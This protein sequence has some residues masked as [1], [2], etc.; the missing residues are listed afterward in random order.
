MKRLF[1]FLCAGGM[2]MAAAFTSGCKKYEEGPLISL[3]PK[4]ERV[5]NTWKIE[6]AFDNG[7]DVTSEYDEYDLYLA[8][9]GYAKL[10]ATYD[11]GIFTFSGSTEGTWKF[12]SNEENLRLDFENNDADAVYRILRLKE[13]ELWLEEAGNGRTLHLQPK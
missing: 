2:M 13:K 9:S 4:K 5:S 3:R 10:T 6:K 8:E 11:Y 7:K 12:E 1:A